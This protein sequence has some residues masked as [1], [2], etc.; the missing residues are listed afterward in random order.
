MISCSHSSHNCDKR[1]SMD[2]PSRTTVHFESN[3]ELRISRL[4]SVI[5]RH[6]ITKLSLSPGLRLDDFIQQVRLPFRTD[7]MRIAVA[8]VV[9]HL[10]C[11]VVLAILRQQ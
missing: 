5:S 7:E 6:P 8:F 10:V 2:I 3:E 11:V 1:G 4:N 9:I